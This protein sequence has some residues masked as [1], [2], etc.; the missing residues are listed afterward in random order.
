MGLC[1]G[2]ETDYYARQIIEHNSAFG[3]TGLV[4]VPTGE[5]LVRDKRIDMHQRFTMG[6][7]T[8]IDVWVLKAKAAPTRGTAV[9]LHGM[10]QHK[11]FYL[12]TGERLAKMGYDVVLLDL[13][14]HGRSGG[15]YVTYGAREKQDVKGVLATLISA[16]SVHRDVYVFG[17]DL[18]AATAIQYAAI[19]P[20][21]KGVLAMKPY[22]DAA[23]MARRK[24]DWAH[25]MSDEDFE[26][27]L[28]R[29]GEIGDF[30][31]HLASSEMAAVSL[32][33]PLLLVH[34]LLDVS[35]PVEHSKAIY[36]AARC[37]KKLMIIMPGPQQLE[38]ANLDKW[39]ADKLHELATI[40]LRE[41]AVAPATQPATKPAGE[42]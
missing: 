18:G 24:I 14:A 7:G 31:P 4:F 36:A 42:P 27:I 34:G 26:K 1:A 32:T 37:P 5:Q 29:A 30:N 39:I 21:C 8:P 40:G 9:L 2:C 35:V 3:K 10:D 22:Q 16:G 23:S 6:D 19:D 28:L 20:N 17:V 41:D 13:R 33:C 38:L 12:G 15:K 25:L 11:F